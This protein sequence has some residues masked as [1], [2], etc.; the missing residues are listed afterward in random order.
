[1]MC[2]M[3]QVR[4]A[5][6]SSQANSGLRLDPCHREFGALTR[7]LQVEN[8]CAV[9]CLNLQAPRITRCCCLDRK[10]SVRDRAEAMSCS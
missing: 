6:A 5:V 4:Q 1:M 10:A 8:G 3:R 9:L 7:P 2:V